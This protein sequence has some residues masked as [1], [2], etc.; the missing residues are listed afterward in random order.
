MKI[1]YFPDEKNAGGRSAWHGSTT[2]GKTIQKFKICKKLFKSLIIF[3]IFEKKFSPNFFCNCLQIAQFAYIAV[4]TQ[5]WTQV[6]TDTDFI[7]EHLSI[8]I[9]M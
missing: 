4:G 3:K 8:R 5:K 1:K 6:I 9:L 7:L 2:S